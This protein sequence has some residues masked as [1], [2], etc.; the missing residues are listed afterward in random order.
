MMNPEVIWD[1]VSSET[2]GPIRL[3]I[4]EVSHRGQLYTVQAAEHLGA[5]ADNHLI[6][7]GRAGEESPVAKKWFHSLDDGLAW[8][9]QRLIE[10]DPN[11]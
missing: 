10:L 6:S 5:G 9:E 3:L 1:F 7:L 2:V 4:Y 8:A 11:S